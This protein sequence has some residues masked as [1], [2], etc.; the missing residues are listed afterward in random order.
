MKILGLEVHKYAPELNKVVF[1]NGV[2][3]DAGN[4]TTISD[5]RR[6]N[7]AP[8]KPGRYCVIK[9]TNQG[10]PDL[11]RTYR[12]YSSYK[13]IQGVLYALKKRHNVP[14]GKFSVSLKYIGA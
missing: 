8:A 2:K 11:N 9:Y 13:A 10:R 6:A 12:G 7:F 1:D 14:G 4:M 3:M 5:F